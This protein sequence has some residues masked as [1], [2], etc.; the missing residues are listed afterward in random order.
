[1][2]AL[3]LFAGPGG[4]DIAAHRLGIGTAGIELDPAAC[5]TRRAAGL[6]TIE[7]DVREYRHL[8]G[9][10]HGQIASPPCQTFSAAGNGSGR[11]ALADVLLGV[12]T[13]S[14][15]GEFSHVFED[16]RTGLVLEPLRWAMLALDKG[17]PFRWLAWEQVPAVLPVWEACAEVLR[18]EGYSVATGVL[19]AEQYGVPQT[20][21]RAVLLA[22]LL[23][24]DRRN[25]PAQELLARLP[26]PT[27]PGAVTIRSTL[28]LEPEVAQQRQWRGA[29]LTS[30]HGER[31]GRSLDQPSFTIAG[32]GA[33]SGALRW[34]DA[35]DRVIR[36]LTVAERAALQTFPADHPWQGTKAQQ[37]GQ[38]SNAVPPL[39]A[40][41][42]LA[43]VTR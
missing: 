10:F 37:Q 23:P 34:A 12:E 30:R 25:Q 7:G 39:L 21:R 1:M 22:Q 27:H 24:T 2:I 8:A 42:I 36:P 11:R 38:V 33:G 32:G 43:E 13:L 5:A 4:W 18:A 19:H 3:D 29:G 20:R 6:P 16:E 40:E 17:S 28:D 9:S 26:V 35:D 14:L 41:A 31:P 15:V